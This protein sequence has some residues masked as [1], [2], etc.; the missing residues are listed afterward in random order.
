MPLKKDW[1]KKHRRLYREI[2]YGIRRAREKNDPEKVT[3]DVKF[4]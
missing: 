4:V 1:M 2:H 3:A